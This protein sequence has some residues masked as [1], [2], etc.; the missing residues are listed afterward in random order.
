MSRR[1]SRE[2]GWRLW[3]IARNISSRAKMICL[4]LQEGGTAEFD[5]RRAGRGQG[6]ARWI[7]ISAGCLP[8]LGRA[9]RRQLL[10]GHLAGASFTDY[11]CSPP[12]P[13][14]HHH[15]LHRAASSSSARQLHPYLQSRAC[16]F[17]DALFCSALHP[18]RSAHP[19]PVTRAAP[20]S[21]QHQTRPPR[22]CRNLPHR[23]PPI[24]GARAHHAARHRLAVDSSS[25]ALSGLH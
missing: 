5:S 25:L 1:A 6:L 19:V 3:Y 9:R 4:A 15:H 2:A 8:V 10:P 12:T 16:S 20:S 14:H 23:H 13:H 17:C 7:E 21:R 11:R 24:A 18:L 22:D